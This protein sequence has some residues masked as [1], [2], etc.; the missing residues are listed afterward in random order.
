MKLGLM[1]AL[2][3]ELG[4]AIA[5]AQGQSDRAGGR[6]FWTGQ[7]HQQHFVAVLSRI[8]KVAAASTAALLIERHQVDA[9]VFTGVAGGLGSGVQ[10]GDAVVA[11]ATLTEDLG[12]E[13][14]VSDARVERALGEPHPTACRAAAARVSSAAEPASE[15]DER[16]AHRAGA[17]LADFTRLAE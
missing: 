6:E 10:V 15:T 16:F 1:G 12:A 9:I 7:W 5:R 2:P 8:G 13:E 11:T 3:E 17:T 4:P 14:R